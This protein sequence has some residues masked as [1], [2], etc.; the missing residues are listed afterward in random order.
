MTE[1]D[2]VKE[3]EELMENWET[4]CRQWV[5][6]ETG[7]PT[8]ATFFRDG[9]I[10]PETWFKDNKL[11]P[12][13]ILK[14]VHDNPLKDEEKD[15]NNYIDFTAMNEKPGHDIWNG[16]GMWIALAT[17][18]KG[19]FSKVEDRDKKENDT[20]ILPYEQL[21]D[22]L[23]NKDKEEY[24]TTLRQIAIIN[25]K[26]L[27]GGGNE[28][29]EQSKQT[30]H[31]KCHAC[32]FK[33]KIQEQIRMI[34]PDVIIFCGSD[35]EECFDVINGKISM[36]E[37]EIPVVNGL[38]PSTNANCRRDTFYYETIKKVVEAIK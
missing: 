11:R 36:G 12:L 35:I 33:E 26:K 22:R 34:D 23:R 28:S 16:K 13:F 2:Y 18:A 24:H 7:V 3:R 17:L 32:K 10:D 15:G 25:L 5:S 19:I 4:E 27:S 31:F 37:K 20:E 1:K 8:T 30:K 38:H 14:E 29:S 9:V 21:Y 6:L